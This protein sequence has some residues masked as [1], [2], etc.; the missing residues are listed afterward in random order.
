[1]VGGGINPATTMGPVAGMGRSV[2]KGVA[3][4]NGNGKY[5]GMGVG[6]VRRGATGRNGSGQCTAGKVEG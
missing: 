1:M 4:G 3:A 6:V 5:A 2:G